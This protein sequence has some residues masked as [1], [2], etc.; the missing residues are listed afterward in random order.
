MA[1]RPATI[2]LLLCSALFSSTLIAASSVSALSPV[3]APTPAA[4]ALETPSAEEEAAR[5]TFE[6]VCSTCHEAAV[7]TTSLRTRQEWSDLLE[8][9]TSFGASASEAQMSQI[10]RYLGRRYGRVNI[11]RAPADEL[12]HVLDI[13]PDV[14]KAIVDYRSTMRFMSAD[15]LKAIA[16]LTATKV[17]AIRP[18]IQ[19]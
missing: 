3:Q 2:Y 4:A 14:A 17:D 5:A 16:G 6:S 18:K 1:K 19:L 12:E 8:M 13:S 11:N 15:D 7:A 9:M 10:Q